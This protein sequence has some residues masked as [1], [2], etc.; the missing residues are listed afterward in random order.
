VSVLERINA[1]GMAVQV[2]GA[3]S[4]ENMELRNQ[5][6][7]RLASQ[8]INL[9]ATSYQIDEAEDRLMARA[10]PPRKPRK[11]AEDLSG[12]RD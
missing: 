11:K 2:L 3:I 8:L 9:Y 6:T 4:I 5:S 12:K 7:A 10:E 1:V